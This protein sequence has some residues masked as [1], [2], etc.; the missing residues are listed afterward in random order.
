MR[1][2]YYIASMSLT[3]RLAIADKCGE[4]HH[5]DCRTNVDWCNA[6]CA[7]QNARRGKEIFAVFHDEHNVWI[8]VSSK[9]FGNVLSAG[10]QDE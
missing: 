6:E 3:A 10:V 7:E 4:T 8:A 1:K 2:G 9:E 5:A